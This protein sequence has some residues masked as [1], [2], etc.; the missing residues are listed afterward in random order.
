[1]KVKPIPDDYQTVTPY[2]IIHGVDKIIEF[3]T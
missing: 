1:M 3:L 2:L